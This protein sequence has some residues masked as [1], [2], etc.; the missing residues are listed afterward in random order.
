MNYL[1]TNFNQ[2]VLALNSRNIRLQ[3]IGKLITLVRICNVD[4]KTI[5]N[6]RNF[7]QLSISKTVIR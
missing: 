1:I 3:L 7:M 6:K 2:Y 5:P 4:R